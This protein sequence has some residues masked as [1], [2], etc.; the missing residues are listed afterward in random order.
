MRGVQ[1]TTAI[2]LIAELG[3]LRR[4]DHPNQPMSYLGLTSSMAVQS[5]SNHNKATCALANKL[6]RICHATLRDQ[7]PYE[8]SRL[9][10]KA[11]R[12]SFAMPA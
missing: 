7:E 8:K 12:L 4:F 11:E 5:P 2:T 9:I 10:H 3:D 1:F 6:A